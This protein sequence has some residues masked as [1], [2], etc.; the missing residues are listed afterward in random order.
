MILAE[1]LTA[2]Y[3]GK[4]VLRDCS[5]QI[6]P[7]GRCAVMGPSG[8]GKTTLLKLLLGL[9]KA[10]SGRAEIRGRAACVFQEPRLLPWR[11]AAQNVNV[12]LA[13]R[14]ETMAEARAWLERLAL[15]EAADLFPEEL[16]GGM[17]QRVAIARALAY[18][19]DALL[20][21]EPLKGLDP[22]L[23]LRTAELILEHSRGKALLLATH[24]REEAAL[25]TDRILMYRDGAFVPE[26]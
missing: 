22:A 23:K 1:K 15:G 6:P 3:A 14:E 12:V 11:T 19:G 7:G 21:D 10:D 5:L 9:R 4:T 13:D 18:G 17:K 25:L 16:S 20:L 26:E 2:A 24:D 8:C